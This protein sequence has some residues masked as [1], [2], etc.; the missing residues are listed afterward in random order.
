MRRY[1]VRGNP[2]EAQTHPMP[3]RVIRY[4]LL[5]LWRRIL[6]LMRGLLTAH[7]RPQ[8]LARGTAIGLAVGITPF[9]GLHF[10]MAM[11]LAHISRA[12]KVLALLT[13]FISNPWTAVPLCVCEGRVAETVFHYDERLFTVKAFHEVFMEDGAHHSII[14]RLH[15]AAT[16]RE[17]G[18]YI[19]RM[20]LGSLILAIPVAGLGY[21][22][23]LRLATAIHHRRVR[24]LARRRA[25]RI[26]QKQQNPAAP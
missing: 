3:D 2:K 6:N 26:R 4:Y 24:S 15:Q 9:W 14:Q 18:A 20:F 17:I 25:Y 10:L 13:I 8:E 19:F 16:R 5:R 21:W 7:V 22:L 12:S 1:G 11:G 23:T